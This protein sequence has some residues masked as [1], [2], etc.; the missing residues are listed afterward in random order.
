MPC[1][2]WPA[3]LLL[4]LSLLPT[5]F[6]FYPKSIFKISHR[7]ER[8]IVA[9]NVIDS[10]DTM[11]AMELWLD[12]PGG[13]GL[14]GTDLILDSLD[15][16]L[17]GIIFRSPPQP[18]QLED[19]ASVPSV[20]VQTS[21]GRLMDA[22]QEEGTPVGVVLSI[23]SAADAFSLVPS[24]LSAAAE[25]PFGSWFVIEAPRS[26]DDA[27]ASLLVAAEAIGK[28][29]NGAR[30]GTRCSSETRVA[31]A[32]VALLRGSSMGGGLVLGGSGNFDEGS[33]GRPGFLVMPLD[34]GIWQAGAIFGNL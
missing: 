10:A 30:L 20:L 25:L 16:T 6:C 27:W 2:F 7:P 29:S 15:V 28:L 22:R 24:A 32:A 13:D 34:I 12:L 11:S 14:L 9:Q 33:L 3:K 18:Q 5:A 1:L 19:V 31:E 23:S 4:A 26:D 21:D 8:L 17:S